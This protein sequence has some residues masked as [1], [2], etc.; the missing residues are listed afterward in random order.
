[1]Y[2]NIKMDVELGQ[3][4][5]KLLKEYK[6]KYIVNSRG[7]VI[8]MTIS[9]NIIRFIVKPSTYIIRDYF[10]INMSFDKQVINIFDNTGEVQFIFNDFTNKTEFFSEPYNGGDYLTTAS[11]ENG[12]LYVSVSNNWIECN[13]RESFA[14]SNFLSCMVR[15][16]RIAMELQVKM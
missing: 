2:N 8:D 7:F 16:H 6:I 3:I 11:N 15:Y 12:H 1:M 4:L 9:N 5:H 14:V 10:K 13:H